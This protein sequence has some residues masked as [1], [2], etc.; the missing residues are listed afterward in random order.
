M[1]EPTQQENAVQQLGGAC[2]KGLLNAIAACSSLTFMRRCQCFLMV[3]LQ[4][5]SMLTYHS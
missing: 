3:D 4:V 1:V 5:T 2:G